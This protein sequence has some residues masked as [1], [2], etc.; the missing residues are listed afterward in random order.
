MGTEPKHLVLNAQI[1]LIGESSGV[2]KALE[3]D[4]EDKEDEGTN[5]PG[6][7]MEELEH[8]DVQRMEHLGK[9]ESD[10]IFRDLEAYGKDH[11]R[12]QTDF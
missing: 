1:L 8:E 2:Q 5:E 3:A 12:L 9:T 4:D 11:P 7:E 10:A 6:E